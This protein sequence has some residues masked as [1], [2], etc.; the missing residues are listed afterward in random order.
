MSN[1]NAVSYFEAVGAAFKSDTIFVMR[2]EVLFN[3]PNP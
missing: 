3:S 2:R 1:S